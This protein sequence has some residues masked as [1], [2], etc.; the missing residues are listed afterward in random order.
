MLISAMSLLEQ[1]A[2]QR[3]RLSSRRLT[4]GSSERAWSKADSG[5]R[6]MIASTALSVSE[7]LVTLQVRSLSIPASKCEIQA[8]RRDLIP[9]TS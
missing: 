1:I 6:K 7:R 3:I 4:V 2:F 8:C 5:A 9:P